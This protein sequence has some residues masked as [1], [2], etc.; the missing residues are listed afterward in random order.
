MIHLRCIRCAREYPAN[1][2]YGC[3]AC[4]GILDVGYAELDFPTEHQTDGRG[5][6][7]Y[8]ALLPVGE[9]AGVISLDEGATPLRAAVRLGRGDMARS[10]HGHS[11][12]DCAALWLKDETVNPTGSFKDRPMTVGVSKAVEFGAPGVIAATSGNA[13]SSLAAYAAKAGLPCLVLVPE[14]AS[15]EKTAQARAYGAQV[16]AVRGNFS[17]AYSLALRFAAERGWANLTTTFINP[18]TVEGDKTTAYE[19]YEQLGGSAPDW[20]IV[21]VGAGP[22]LVGIFKGFAELQRMGLIPR[23]PKIAGVQA[24]G[25]GPLAEAFERGSAEVIAWGEPRTIALGI[26]DP[27]QGYA[28]DGTHTLQ[29][30]RESGGLALA[31]SDEA[32]LEAVRQLARMC[33]VFAEPAGAAPIAALRELRRREIVKADEVVVAVIT[34]HGLKDPTAA[35][36][37]EPPH[38]IEASLEALLVVTLEPMNPDRRHP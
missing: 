18:Y 9:G 28:Q 21:P 14:R 35:V 4:G 2:R 22:L 20:A 34:G 33:G 7:K 3:E 38:I 27:L 29:T 6:W 13:G 26:S 32:I 30:I 17:D 36:G 1:A 37:V 12:L 19:I 15:P 11:L 24:A 31:V 8:R 5:V 23:A 16:V 25:C 10:A